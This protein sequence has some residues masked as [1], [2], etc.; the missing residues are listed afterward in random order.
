L[1]P[2]P[3]EI[4]LTIEPRTLITAKATLLDELEAQRE[5]MLEAHKNFEGMAQKLSEVDKDY[6][7]G[8]TLAVRYLLARAKESALAKEE[9]IKVEK[10]K[11]INL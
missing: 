5:R 7:R 6:E 3:E 11:S 1:K 4:T 9:Q 2:P 8:L 10:D